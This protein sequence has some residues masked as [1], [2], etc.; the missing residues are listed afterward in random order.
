MWPDFL[1]ALIEDSHAR[2]NASVSR[3]RSGKDAS[4]I[5]DRSSFEIILDTA[6]KCG[7]IFATEKAAIRSNL[8]D[9]F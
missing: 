8:N 4:S 3:K 7:R 2:G 5:D 1:N 6:Y 9:G